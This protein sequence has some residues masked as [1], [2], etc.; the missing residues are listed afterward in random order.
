MSKY[1]ITSPDI[2]TF[3]DLYNFLQQ[4]NDH[5]IKDWLNVSWKG[6]DKQE[7]VVR[8]FAGL[9]CITKLDNFNICKGNFNLQTLEPFTSL[10]DIFYHSDKKPISL[11]DKGD[12]SDLSGISKENSKHLLLTTSKNNT[13]DINNNDNLNTTNIGK[14]D[15][16]KI[17][18]NFEDYRQNGYTYTLCIVTRERIKLETKV[19]SAEKSSHKIK[20]AVTKEDTII[21]DW[22]DLDEAYRQFKQI[23]SNISITTIINLNKSPLRFKLHQ[24]LGIQKTIKIKSSGNN[25][26]LWGHIQRSGKSYIMAGTIEEDSKNSKKGCNY[27]IIT[28]AP[29]ET[30]EQYIKVFNCIQLHSFNVIYLHAGN[31]K[32]TLQDKNIIIC[33]KQFLQNKI[34]ESTES[35]DDEKKNT[36]FTQIKWLKDIT[37]DI[38]FIDESHNGGT[39]DLAQK[40]L[41]YYSPKAFTVQITATY[42]KPIKDYNIPKDCWV[43]WDLEDIKCCKEIEQVENRDKL[44]EKHGKEMMDLLNHSSNQ[45]ISEEY[46]HYPELWI[47]TDRLKPEIVSEIITDTSNNQYGWST[48]ACFLLKQNKNGCIAEFQNEEEN[49]KLW[50]RIFGKK[51]RLGVPSPDYPDNLVFMKRIEMICKN[52]SIHSRHIGNM[53]GE[54]MIIMAFLP[55]N[56]IDKVSIASKDVLEK[57]HI[58]PN[59]EIVI[60]NSK[61]SSNPKE[62]IENGRKRAKHTGKDGVLVLSGKQCSLGISIDN[63]DIV[64]LLNSNLSF[65]M[66]YQMMFRAM[67]EGKNKKCGFVIDLNLNRTID[68]SIIEYSSLIKSDVHPKEAVQYILQ[69]RLINLNGDHWLPIFGNSL[70]SIHSISEQIY[71]IYTSNTQKALHQFL[72][73]IKFKQI[74]LSDTE[75]KVMNALFSSTSKVTQSELDE[76]KQGI[77]QLKIDIVEDEDEDEVEDEDEDEEEKV[78]EK[79]KEKQIVNYMDV[80]KHII[81]L[82]CLLSIHNDET[83]FI[84]MYTSIEQSKTLHTIF[85]DQVKS[86]WSEN[87]DLNSM[88]KFINIYVKYMS[89]NKEINQIITLVKECFKK[90]IN[91]SSE[92][93]SLIDT[94]LIPQELEKKK[95]AEVSTPHKLRQEMLDKIPLEFWS[96]G[97]KV[98]EPCS[99]KGGFLVDI[100]GRFMI[101]L[102]DSIKDEKK[103]YKYIVE[104]CI[105]F[106]DINP[107]NIFICKLLLD[108]NNQYKLN[109]NEGNTLELNTTQKWKTEHFDAV[110][111]N[112]PYQEVDENNKSKGGTNLYTKFI[113][114]CFNI[115]KQKG[116]LLFIT[117]ISWLGPSTNKQ[118][119]SDILHNIFLKYDLLFLNL[120]ECKKHFSVGSTFS[121]YLIQN[122][123]TTNIMTDIVS[124]HKKKV[125]SDKLDFKKIADL[126]FL[127]IHIT[128]ET[129]NLIKNV[130]SKKNKIT[131]NRCR[132]L[133]TST[134]SGKSK[135]KL[136]KDKDFK[137][138]TYH[139][140][141]KTYY[142]NE[143]LDIYSDYKI[144]LN[145]AGYLKPVV[146]NNCNITESKFYIK[147][148]SVE[149]GQKIIDMLESEE[150][151][152]YLE[153]CKY[154]GFNSRIVIENITY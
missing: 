15:I 28:T 81:P 98:F 22:N 53:N 125:C 128:S 130:I 83:S 113:N 124:E 13:S 26:A 131:I 60:I 68:T 107:T 2:S 149:E 141:T 147:V 3:A 105:Y 64:I 138:I 75:Q 18:T 153:L 150:I 154:S 80:L 89:N 126:K 58:I 24:L 142:S 14:L 151:N 99:G 25:R 144:L 135:L 1:C 43:L 48:E 136:Q 31:K 88:K 51:S 7:S 91:N 146:V 55:Q 5:S 85:L 6:K 38:R 109:Y 62:E 110:I 66:I 152:T 44:I 112:P 137:Y 8:L 119:G 100:L 132:I 19:K 9:K 140:T 54:P 27:L 116:Y 69:E 52:P 115:V 139:T 17:I 56:N 77:E 47:L 118:M 67:T 148:N 82:V 93:S 94:Y 108:P 133:D 16:E 123:I 70:D 20:K 42:L 41:D 71:T 12:S 46:I 63:C 40:V 97:R 90:S 95:N 35:E 102:K 50:Y 29:N 57:Y 10:K 4:Y 114:F 49:C 33:S 92:L 111:G 37:F 143:K 84:K 120:N 121:Y 104:E 34:T 78:E 134:K 23:Y 87:I 129:I 21:I 30:I 39:T 145:M 106:S 72:N 101:G 59:F 74:I 127:P 86:W 11:K 32:P 76:I 65:D 73:R 79:K 61:S 117:P 96:K 45:L 103:R 36:R 122:S